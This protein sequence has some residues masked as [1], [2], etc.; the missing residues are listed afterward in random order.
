MYYSGFASLF[1]GTQYAKEFAVVATQN[2]T[3]VVITPHA[4]T[5]QNK[6]KNTPFSVRLNKGE[7]YLVKSLDESNDLSGTIVQANAPVALFAGHQCANVAANDDWC[8]HII[9]QMIPTSM[10]GKKFAITKTIGQYTNRIM[11][12]AQYDNTAV[13]VNGN[14]LVTLN[15]LQ[16]FEF[17]MERNDIS[18]YVESTAPV[19]CYLYSEGGRRNNKVGDPSS[20]YICPIEQS[21]P[22]ITFATL[23][24]SRSEHNYINIVVPTAYADQTLFDGQPVNRVYTPLAGNP[25]FSYVRMEI[26]HGTHTLTNADGGVIAYVYGLGDGESYAYMVGC[27]TIPLDAQILVDNKPATQMSLKTHCRKHVFHFKPQVNMDYNTVSWDFGDG[28]QAIQEN[29]QHLYTS[30]GDYMVTMT[31]TGDSE[32]KVVSTMLH[33]SDLLR[34]TIEVTIC[35]GDEYIFNE[36]SYTDAGEYSE[37]FVTGDGCDSVVAMKLNVGETYRIVE[38]RFMAEGQIVRWRGKR[39]SSPGTYR[40]TLP[41]ITGCDSIFELTIVQMDAPLVQYD[42][43][44][45]EPTYLFMGH[46]YP[47]PPVD[48]YQHMQYV[49]YTLEYRDDDA[50]RRYFMHLAIVPDYNVDSVLYDTISHGTVYSWR[51]QSIT[52]S[53]SYYDEEELG[54]HSTKHYTLHLVVKPYPIEE[55]NASLCFNGTY[56]F[57]GKELTTPG[58]YADTVFS[59]AGIGGIYRVTLTDNR[60]FEELYIDHVESY[61]FNGKHLTQSGTYRDTLTNVMGCDSI[62]TLYLGINEKCTVTEEINYNICDGETYSWNEQTCLPGNDYSATFIAVNG[63]DSVVT[64]HLN[65]LERKQVTQDVAICEGDYYRVGEVRL[66]DA[67]THVVHLA[68]MQ[69]CDST[70]TVNLTINENYEISQSAVINIGESYEWEGEHYTEAGTYYKTL[71]ASNGC[72]SLRILELEVNSACQESRDTT[73]VLCAGQTLAWWGNEYAESGDFQYLRHFD[74]KCDTLIT[75]HLTVMPSYDDMHDYKT[76]CQGETYS[77]EG[78]D[79]TESGSYTRTLKTIHNC[80]S[81][82][83]LHLTVYP[84]YPNR[85]ETQYICAGDYYDWNGARYTDAGDYTVHLNTQSGCD[86][87]V[88][89]HLR[90]HPRYEGIMEI[91]TIFAGEQYYWEG[92]NYSETLTETKN[93]HSVNGCDSIVT[94]QLTVLQKSTLYKDSIANIC[95]GDVFDFYGN[96]LTIAD[97]YTVTRQGLNE[98]TVIT[99]HLSV[100]PAYTIEITDTILDGQ[101]FVLGDKSYSEKGD[102]VLNHV[103]EYGCDSIVT[104]HLYTNNIVLNSVHV[105][106]QCADDQWFDFLIDV[107]GTIHQVN[108]L[109]SENAHQAGL[110]DT[111]VSLANDGMITIPLSARAGEYSAVV[112]LVF[113]EQ[114]VQTMTVP[115]TILYPSSVLEQAWNDVVAVLAHNYNGG[116]DFV[117]FQWY[118]NG[119]PLVGE[120]HSY[121]Y[122][123]LDMGSEYSAMLTE[124]NGT[125]LMTCP[126]VASPQTDISLYPT[127]A[128]PRQIV[129]CYANEEAILTLYDEVGKKLM[130]QSLTIGDNPFAAPDVEGVYLVKIRTTRNEKD[131]LYK[132]IIQ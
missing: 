20:V 106:E 19:A 84:V 57:R 42:T 102:Y 31:V 91:H 12:T 14:L 90:H 54:C 72:D 97:T 124:A 119:R 48:A 104:L 128:Q 24:T 28:T 1:H 56:S 79:Y 98:D 94:L 83:T 121:L 77:W 10:W 41:T 75:L 46:E 76:I 89:L 117:A 22:N 66:T 132:I 60:N 58:I 80:D 15:A 93:L 4:R 129:H 99:L 64:L 26:S 103:S 16:T 86:S 6:A 108:I 65:K 122:R 70:V 120:T 92:V 107:Q 50:C 17:Q 30:A 44:C 61:D 78:I 35:E 32:T 43:L 49:P 55:I 95:E 81:I 126:L 11:V 8:D 40:D 59:A 13:S 62:I 118:E 36:H 39:L 114:I 34:D 73:A 112:Q 113:R 88:T 47:I 27:S 18:C 33:L 3:T 7:T 110:R 53:G 38:K 82:V 130:T 68:T 115:L 25:Q 74:N 101:T 51:N 67:G 71:T 131:K 87:T 123:P 9:E 37:T 116:Y 23:K 127:I 21:L 5:V 45:Y 69:G 105:D 125:Q 109:F 96:K 29:P 85:E 52:Q 100:W 111:T 63:C 2:N